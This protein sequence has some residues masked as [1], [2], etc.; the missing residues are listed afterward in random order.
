M[1]EKSSTSK[2]FDFFFS[3]KEKITLIILPLRRMDCASLNLNDKFANKILIDFSS[4]Y[5]SIDSFQIAR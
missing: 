5:E 2:I 4:A 3:E 1:L